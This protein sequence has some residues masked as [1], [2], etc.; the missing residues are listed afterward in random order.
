MK[1]TKMNT[2]SKN[3]VENEHKEP[4]FINFGRKSAGKMNFGHFFPNGPTVRRGY[5][6]LQASSS[7][8]G[9]GMKSLDRYRCMRVD[10]DRETC[11]LGGCQNESAIAKLVVARSKRGSKRVKEMEALGE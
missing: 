9:S 6:L 11:V 2:A 5:Q 3:S 10:S 4:S 1:I 8:E 7:A